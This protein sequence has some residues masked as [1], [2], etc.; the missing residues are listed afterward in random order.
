MASKTTTNTIEVDGLTVFYRE[1]GPKDAPVILL[2][3][4][5]PSSSH[6]YRNLIPLL[7]HK[8]H[9]VA[10]DLPGFGFTTV[11]A[12]RHYKYTFEN[13][14]TST[15]AFLDAL[16]I[17]KFSVYIFDYGAPTALRVALRRPDAVQAIISQNGNAYDDGIGAF[18][19]PLRAYWKSNSAEDR[20]NIRANLLTF[21]ATKW[22][23]IN[24]AKH[25]VA[26]EAYH[27]DYALLSQPGN[28]EVQLDLFYDYQNNVKLY[29]EF[30]AYFRDS[31]VPLLAAWGKNDTIFIKEGAEA[32][33]RDLPKVELKLLDAGHF[34]VE[35]DTD[36]IANLM[37]EFLNKNGI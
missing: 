28:E 9:I 24:G 32:F 35:S 20:E 4:G 18:W 13:L 10:P 1:A 25:L 37:L 34:V 36:E 22:Q 26:P 6:Q 21:E 23:Y 3:H 17:K 16:A 14:A 5:F 19:D 12:S 8:Y 31:Q 27:L 2:L 15:E 33:K 11:P 30:Q 29:P 7:S